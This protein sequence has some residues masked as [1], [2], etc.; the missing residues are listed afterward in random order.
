MK[1]ESAEEKAELIKDLISLANS[2][3][4]KAYS[5]IGIDNKSNSIGADNLEEERIQQIEKRN[6]LDS[7]IEQT[8][9]SY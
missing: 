7:N 8:S 5:I 9:R 2:A 3:I 1:L 6:N 4:E